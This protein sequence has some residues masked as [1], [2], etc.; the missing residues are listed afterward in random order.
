MFWL[1][2]FIHGSVLSTDSVA[3][4]HEHDL[5]RTDYHGS[6]WP[7]MSGLDSHGIF[8]IADRD[9]LNEKDQLTSQVGSGAAENCPQ[10]G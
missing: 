9:G 4:L 10:L 1:C 5:R 8:L 3:V 6:Q 2:Y 7:T